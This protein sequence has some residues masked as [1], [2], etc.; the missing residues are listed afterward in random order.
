ME[1]ANRARSVRRL[2]SIIAPRSRPAAPTLT[3]RST[4]RW[5]SPRPPRSTKWSKSP[6][7]TCGPASRP[8]ASRARN[9]ALAQK[10]ANDTAEPIKSGLSEGFKNVA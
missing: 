2:P 9:A 8:W 6:P 7:R 4:G 10:A 3:P 1:E 5:R